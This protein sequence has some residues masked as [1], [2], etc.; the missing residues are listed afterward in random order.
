MPFDPGPSTPEQPSRGS[1]PNARDASADADP[2]APQPRTH[3]DVLAQF[4]DE[5]GAAN[6]V[7]AHLEQVVLDELRDRA[8]ATEIVLRQL[9]TRTRTIKRHV[10]HLEESVGTITQEYRAIEE[11]SRDAQAALADFGQAEAAARQKLAYLSDEYRRLEDASRETATRLAA[12]SS[13]IED[14]SRATG[15][16]LI[17]GYRKVEDAS[18][19]TATRLAGDYR[20]VE[21]AA[22]HAAAQLASEYS[23]A[24]E[25]AR[26]AVTLSESAVETLKRIE[27]RLADLSLLHDLQKIEHRLTAL[28]DLADEIDEK[29]NRRARER[30]ERVRAALNAITNE[31]GSAGADQSPNTA[32]RVFDALLAGGRKAAAIV[33]HRR[34]RNELIPGSVSQAVILWLGVLALL[35]IMVSRSGTGDPTGTPRAAR[36]SLTAAPLLFPPFVLSPDA[37]PAA[38]ARTAQPAGVPLLANSRGTASAAPRGAT[39]AR[40]PAAAPSQESDSKFVG[41]LAVT[42]DPPGAAVIIDRRRVGQTPLQLRGVQSGSRVVWIE[43]DGYVRWTAAVQVAAGRVTRVSARLDPSPVP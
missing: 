4:A 26:E 28:D 12:E 43:R 21:D 25:N 10:D 29:L 36:L 22:Q 24:G 30:V 41:S 33:T 8:P 34:V 19:E 15:A 9:L 27:A 42:S 32:V 14:V 37:T 39:A 38:I 18:R 2:Q 20:Q 1:A 3:D 31:G 7:Q 35:G 23:K 13:K 40:P 16:R 17:E 5:P 11:A 6:T